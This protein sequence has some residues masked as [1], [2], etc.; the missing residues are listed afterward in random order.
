MRS[1]YTLAR[2]FIDAPL[3]GTI[4]LPREQS[5]YLAT[6]LRKRDGDRVRVFNGRDGEWAAG[7]EVSGR[8]SVSLRVEERLRGPQNTPDIRLLFAPLRRHRT[9]TVLEKA[10]EL[11]VQTLQPVITARTQFPKLNL[12]RGRAQII[13][14]AEQTERLDLPELCEPVAL[15]EAL[16]TMQNG[17][18]LLFADEA[19]D[20]PEA[21]HALRD[22]HLPLDILIGPEGGFTPDE[23]SAIRSLVAAR[24]IS[25]GPRILRADTA[26]LAVLTLVQA[27]CGDW[28]QS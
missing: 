10:T 6:V 3:R 19:G 7:V 28:R 15:A 13:E 8:K 20:A 12:D 16:A 27:H 4:E 1:D 2:L 11:G 24:P 25:L 14:A 21:V 9:A 23:R 5:H 26:A 22:L 17:R 18:M